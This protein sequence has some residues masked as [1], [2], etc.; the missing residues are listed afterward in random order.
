MFLV[1]D[2]EGTMPIASKSYIL[3]FTRSSA[4]AV[5]VPT[6]DDLFDEAFSMKHSIEMEIS[7]GIQ[8]NLLTSSKR[9]FDIIC[10]GKR[11]NKEKLMLDEYC[12]HKGYEE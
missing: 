3:R 7:E 10:K 9:S 5:K 6:F 11:E 12:A 2:D 8:M 4:F 1:P